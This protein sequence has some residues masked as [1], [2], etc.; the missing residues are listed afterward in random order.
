MGSS[1]LVGQLQ[2]LDWMA[3]SATAWLAVAFMLITPAL[4]VS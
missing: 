3:Y 2:T 4:L 1:A